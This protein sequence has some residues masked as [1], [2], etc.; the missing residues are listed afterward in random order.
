MMFWD[1]KRI[2][3]SGCGGFI[4]SAL[5]NQICNKKL[6]GQLV[7]GIGR[8]FQQRFEQ[9]PSPSEG[10]YQIHCD[11]TDSEET[12]KVIA[13][14]RPEL[15]YHCAAKAT[16]KIEHSLDERQMIEQ[17]INTTHNLLYAAHDVIVVHTS[18]ILV[19]DRILHKNWEHVKYTQPNPK[20]MYGSTKLAQENIIKSC[21]NVKKG[22]IIRLSAVVGAGSSHGML[23]D[24]IKKAQSDSSTFEIF[25]PGYGC[26]K[27][28]IY[29]GEVVDYLM[30]KMDGA[31]LT[32]NSIGA[33]KVAKI[34]MDEIG[35]KKE[36]IYNNKQFWTGDTPFII[37]DKSPEIKYNSEESIRLAVRD[38]L[39]EQKI[40]E[41]IRRF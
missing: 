3:I 8:R 32:N 37:N 10:Q 30:Y 4:G 11:L 7:I 9:L 36:I 1:H 29:L 17:N 40:Q 12:A 28:Y 21:K 24:F 31:T 34:V 13:W 39:E 6:D 5:Y 20:S 27:P 16:T 14:A 22:N 38:I 18:S 33:E 41:M 26:E 23:R 35:V 2:L 19:W 15:I 25:G